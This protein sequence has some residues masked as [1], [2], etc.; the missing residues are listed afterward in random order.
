MIR[1]IIDAALRQ[2]LLVLIAAAV[3]AVLG[4]R[5][6]QDT[7]LDALPDLSDVQVIIRTSY[8]GQ[9]PQQVEQQVT[10]PLSTAML[11]V[12][13]ARTVRGYS[14][15]GD[16]YVYVIFEDGVDLYWARSR[17]LEYLNQVT[18]PEAASPR[19]GPDATGVGWVYQYA[20]VDR[21]GQHDLGELRALQDWFLRY[22]LQTVPGVSEVASVGGMVRQFDIT[23][24]PERLRAHDIDLQRI[25]RAV[26]ANNSEAGG[27]SIELAG[28]EYMLRGLGYVDGVD[29]LRRVPLGRN[30]SGVPVTLA[31]VATIN[32]GP[33]PRR[34]IAELD[35]DGEVAGGIVVMRQGGDA[36]QV[37]DAVKQRIAELAPGLPAGVEIVPTYDRSQ[38]IR[39]AVSNLGGK[40][41]EEFIVV[42]L[43]CLIFLLHLRSALVAVVT[44]PI[45][46][47]A[48]FL[49]M[50]WQGVNANIM[51]LGGIAIA[52]GAMVDAAIVMIE[53]LHAHRARFRE[54]EGRD[55]DAAEHWRIVRD[56]SI[57]VG[58]AL[59]VSLLIIT[60][61][62]LPVFALQGQEG[63]LFS[64]LAFTKSYA[65]AAAAGLSI[66]LIPVLMGWLV[67]GRIPDEHRNPINRWLEHAYRPLL[68]AA[69]RHP[70][71]LL[72]GATIAL[73]LTAI[74]WQRL[75]SEFLP[76]MDEGDL[77]YMP[78]TLPGLSPAE[79]AALLQRTDRLIRSVPEV[80]RVFGKV[81]RADTATDP[82][83]LTMV[84]TTIQLKPRSEWREGMDSQGLIDELNRVVKLP[85]IT[86]LW[87]PPIR[88]RLDMLS[89]GVKGPLGIRISGP[90]PAELQRIG[91]KIERLVRQQPGV[92]SA[93]AERSAGGR[94][95]DVE[96]D[97]AA[98]ARYGLDVADIQRTLSRAIG[99]AR[100]GEV[101]DGPRRFPI[102][103][104]F[105]RERRDSLAELSRLP[106]ITDDGSAVTLGEVAMLSFADGPPM[107]KSENA[108][109]VSWVF[110]DLEGD[111]LGGRVEGLKQLL[112]DQLELPPGYSLGW[113]GQYE[114]L[115]RARARLL[116]VVPMVLVVILLLLHLHFGRLDD[117]LM[118]MLGLPFALI[119]GV[120]LMALLDHAF[121]V[122]SAV[123]F[124]ALAGVAAEFGVV[125]LVYL[126]SAWDEERA[127]GRSG[128]DDLDA[129]IRHGAL[130][131]LRPK[132]MTVAVILAGLLPILLGHGPGSEL[133]QRIAAPMV[134]GMLTAPLLSM[135]LLPV[136]FRWS[137]RRELQR[138]R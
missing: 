131:R 14:F 104:R 5:A 121:S 135:L 100:I 63:R 48:A 95:I 39:G 61:S 54:H 65:M 76:L 12:P 29:D 52:I 22:E 66:T 119:G 58:P 38:L 3:L 42:A 124:I 84:E 120:W 17:V 62:F 59:F 137:R 99:G 123:G 118:V 37:I 111:D 126:R 127:A 49:L 105:P 28:A 9:A 77:L 50:R 102:A 33:A 21:S 55:P 47:L 113:S 71:L 80:E 56:A 122:A 46:V 78:T 51:S 114:H 134:G 7:P 112:A 106:I 103:M 45:G 88:N 89:T 128:L 64:P 31:D 87:V 94:Y 44:L 2:R 108:R 117:A 20:L 60:L 116:Q 15:F 68:D 24:D 41:V 86:N 30:A 101:V 67:R 13:G 93:L 136:L 25:E 57:E 11:S 8:P 4:L 32:V 35:G 6:L 98:A 72:G 125:M 82:A 40:L 73:A 53:N 75:G 26:S 129:A 23:L 92:R 97:R 34:G 132:A 36:L 85:G 110:V 16:S 74:P 138:Q 69:L 10:Y 109:L 96:P 1:A 107:L 91:G 43:V 81:G 90:E 115:E 27:A 133:M 18:L 83:P 19:L 79:A 130:K 70:R